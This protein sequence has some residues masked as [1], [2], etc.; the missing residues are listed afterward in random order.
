MKTL[1]SLLSIYLMTSGGGCEQAEFL[2]NSRIVVEGIILDN[3]QRPIG[4]IPIEYSN[5]INGIKILTKT[6]GKFRIST[7]QTTAK[8]QITLPGNEIK[9]IKASNTSI[10]NMYNYIYIPE[11]INYAYLEITLK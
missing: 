9:S 8:T 7:P 11:S 4:N 1:I 3:S 2:D 10:T 5:K 6:D